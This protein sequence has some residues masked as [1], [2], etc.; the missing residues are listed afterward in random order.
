VVTIGL[1]HATDLPS[2]TCCRAYVGGSQGS[3]GLGKLW[4][5]LTS[6]LNPS[7]R[8]AFVWNLTS[9]ETERYRN[10]EVEDQLLRESLPWFAKVS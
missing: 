1:I 2:G 10:E 7:R 4:P 8:R 3:G 6:L 9:E 5:A